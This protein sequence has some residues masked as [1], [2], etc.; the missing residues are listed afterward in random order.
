M[1][2]LF[3]K[4]AN[5]LDHISIKV[6][7]IVVYFVFIIIPLSIFTFVSYNRIHNL[8]IHQTLNSASQTFDE[9]ADIMIRSFNNMQNCM[10]ILLKN[11]DIYES[12]TTQPA[13]S[14]AVQRSYDTLV[15]QFSYL[16]DGTSV[17]NIRFFVDNIFY[18]NNS[19]IFNR[20]E[21]LNSEWYR[22]LKDSAI[23]R[24]WVGSNIYDGENDSNKRFFSYISLM[25]DLNQLQKDI[26]VISVDVDELK[27]LK[28]LSNASVTANSVVYLTDGKNIIL[29]NKPLQMASEV[30]F[31]EFTDLSYSSTD[32]FQYQFN[33]SKVFLRYKE[34]KPT[35]WY[36]VSVVP[37]GD[38]AALG[39]M[40]RNEMI[41]FLLILASISYFLAY[42]ISNSSLKR[43]YILNREIKNMNSGNLDVQIKQ[44][45]HDEI[46]QIMG[47]LNNMVISMRNLVKEKFR[48]GQEIK[49]A[50]LKALQAQINPHFLYNSLD[51]INCSAI[52]NNIPEIAQMVNALAKFYKLSLSRGKDL[53]P[54]R[55]ELLHASLYVQIQNLRYEN[56]ADLII[57]VQDSLYEIFTL[58]IILQPLVENSILHG[59]LEKDS[60]QGSIKISGILDN[61]LVKL[62]VTDNGIGMSEETLSKLLREDDLDNLHGYGIKNIDNRIK[63]FYGYE[64]G[65]SFSSEPNEGTT[66][67]IVFPAYHN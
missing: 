23:N 7:I 39:N 60:C 26:A 65:L 1:N 49:N 37:K 42:I 18:S 58:K 66:V 57:D 4:L 16:Q 27:L 19:N 24:L 61:G 11:P 45:G 50:E 30:N 15:R 29:S 14:I 32:W 48:M 44:S 22:V 67:N 36:L 13:N 25:Y 64:Y 33:N 34:L 8:V 59:I 10:T 53:I 51:L 41:L 12:V 63:L 6:K 21:I 55:D 5:Y 31:T 35:S 28:A 43:L 62:S 17:D 47:S 46:G 40:I 9:S 52:K 2:K 38:L 20:K 56:C 54:L 3:L